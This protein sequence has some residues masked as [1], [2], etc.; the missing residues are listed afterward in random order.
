MYCMLLCKQSGEN[1]LQ[2]AGPS[3]RDWSLIMSREEGEG[4]L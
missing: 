4:G 3:I 2:S 1:V